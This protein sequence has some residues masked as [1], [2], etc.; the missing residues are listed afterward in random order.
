MSLDI[1]KVSI[2]SLVEFVMRSGSIDSRIKASVR[3]VEGIKGHKKIQSEYSEN[4]KSEVSLKE[5]VEFDDFILR[6]EGRADGILNEGDK[7]IID[8][9]K[10]TTRNVMDIDE[11]YN[12]LH[13]AQA[14]I[15]AYIYG[16]EKK[17]DE[18]YVQLTYY[19]IED[20]TTKY[21]RKKYS[22]SELTEFF[23]NIVSDYKEWVLREKAWK[24]ER[25]KSI[26]NLSFPFKEYRKGQRELAIRVY[27]AIE[28][29]TKCLAQAPTGTGKTISTLF[30]TIKSLGNDFTSKI[31][32]L[33]AK[34]TTRAV[35]NSSVDLMRK[36]GLKLRSLTLTAKDKCCKMDEKKCIPEYCPYANGY[37]DRVNF[38]LK[39]ALDNKGNYDFEYISSLTDKFNICPFEFSLEL[40]N[41]C[42]LIICDY[43]YIFD[44]QVSLKS[45][46]DSKAKEYTLLIDE[47]HNLVDRGREMYSATLNKK[48]FLELKREFKN[49]DK[50]IFNSL[51]KI[52][53]YFIEKRNVLE[54]LETKTL[55]EKE[56]GK[57]LLGMLRGF[58]ELVDIFQSKNTEENQKLLDL[59]FKVYSFLTISNFYGEEFIT[60]YKEEKNDLEISINCLDPSKMLKGIMSSFKSNII[61]SATLLPIE[62][63]KKVYGYIEEDY[64]INLS[65]PFDSHNKLTIVGHDV[66][67]TYRNRKKS[68]PKVVKYIKELAESKVGN[69]LVF[70]PSYEY[71]IMA[72]DEFRF[73]NLDISIKAQENN[74]DEYDKA[75][76]LSFFKEDKDKSHIGF[77]V[78]GGHFSE[79][80]DLDREKL[81]G[82]II[83]GVGMPKVCLEREAIKDYYDSLGEN[84][85]DYAYVYPGIIKVLQGAGR[86]IRTEDDKGIV[87]LL[88][89]RYFSD[90]YKALLPR[91]WYN[92]IQVQSERSIKEASSAFWKGLS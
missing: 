91:E 70:F 49:K 34:T 21:L 45:A 29:G 28:D 68:L 71:M 32:Y 31:F 72:Y 43:N 40:T 4:S 12:E 88:D 86:C 23:E 53:K 59:Y 55:M 84:G 2:R 17:L 74:M 66:S 67:T 10:T 6:V 62:Y 5:E 46:M 82:V 73:L 35:A 69:Y 36:E 75:L 85:F 18:I 30:P 87:L 16:K 14:K 25:N 90:K 19:N 1:I 7:V 38:A 57:E 77:A 13:W 11:N 47:A 26:E 33:T 58:L 3:A 79:G 27:K 20:F 81:I 37:F 41:W 61:F 54:E 83:V 78:L 65:S 44:P 48:E 89:D 51:T 52:N 15:Y 39:E 50:G 22:L 56:E 64:L 9:I 42:D 92:N 80:I 8:E 60:L 24:D 76:Y 63:F